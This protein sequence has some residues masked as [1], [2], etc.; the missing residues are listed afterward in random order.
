MKILLLITMIFSSTYAMSAE[1]EKPW[2]VFWDAQHN[3][4]GFKDANGI[5]RIKPK[6]MG[7]TTAHT[8][9]NII[10]AME[11]QNGK[12]TTYYLLKN[13]KKVGINN[14]YVAPMEFDCESEES[15]RF[16]DSATDKVG[17]YD[18][19]GRVIIPAE[20]NYALP[21]RNGL[22]VALKN[23]KRICYHG[24]EYSKEKRCEHWNWKG[25]NR[26]LIN[27]KNKVLISNFEYDRH[28]DF[29]SMRISD[30]ASQDPS[31]SSFRG[32]NGKYY[33]FINI[34]KKFVQWLQQQ[35]LANLSMTKLLE[36]THSEVYYWNDPK[37]WISKDRKTFIQQNYKKLEK[38]LQLIM[39]P[40][41]YVKRSK[42]NNKEKAVT[43]FISTVGLNPY[44]YEKEAYR[45][46]FDDCWNPKTWKYPAL[47][48]VIDQP[49]NIDTAQS[50]FDFLKTDDGFRLTSVTIR[51]DK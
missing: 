40:K 47:S 22:A 12:I 3:L 43:Y 15:I 10:A 23:A 16:R 41:T 44:I 20:Y 1:K 45:K 46:Y 7:L 35:L 48:V 13:G 2:T 8:F 18:A 50:L 38:K 28:L 14:T 6:F 4:K 24:G 32:N 42:V 26:S 29:Y 5:T 25:G 9:R 51:N 11:E 31:V 33:H 34:K 27:K 36:N 49:G 21:F 37:G 17:F 30:N 39:N 19:T